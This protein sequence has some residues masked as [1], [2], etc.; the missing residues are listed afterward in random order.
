V[1]PAPDDR[2][3]GLHAQLVAATGHDPFV[4]LDLDP[5]TLD[6]I[7]V[8]DG[9]AAAYRS[10]HPW[11][12]VH[13]VTGLAVDPGDAAH[14]DAAAALIA[15]VVAS[16]RADGI[17][18]EGVTVT[19]GGLDR[20]PPDL[21]PATYHEWDFWHTTA[22]PPADGRLTTYAVQ[23]EVIDVAGDDPRLEPLLALASPTAS[24]RPGDP[25]V[26]RWAVIEDPDSGL[27]DTGGL[28]A[29][30][31]VTH[32]RSGAAH[33]N[34][35]A[36]HPDR[37]GRRLSRRLCSAVTVDALR[38]G[39]PAVTLGMY[40]DNDAARALYTALG[41]TCLRGQTSGPVHHL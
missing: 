1:T 22:E 39:R 24:L 27:L 18:V 28:A 35:V 32:Q 10:Y 36:T 41:F 25:R 13:W 21:R 12:D 16:T 33:L 37:R 26:A 17:E 3:R 34:D 9:Q 15:E 30:V 4:T 23:P 19:R 7:A 20:L 31:A 6:R 11:R 14:L 5:G 8:D 2:Q 38:E 29:V 40:A